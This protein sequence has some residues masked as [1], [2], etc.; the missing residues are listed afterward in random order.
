[1][2]PVGQRDFGFVRGIFNRD[3]L[4]RLS[5]A[6]RFSGLGFA[7]KLLP[8]PACRLRSAAAAPGSARG[9][10]VR[11]AGPGTASCPHLFPPAIVFV[12]VSMSTSAHTHTHRRLYTRIHIHT[13]AYTYTHTYPYRYGDTNMYPYPYPHIRTRRHTHISMYIYIHLQTPPH[14]LYIHIHRNTHKPFHIQT[15]I[16]IEIRTHI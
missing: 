4:L 6:F 8:A 15:P 16:P 7:A 13:H 1:M 10:S 11:P 14:T 5:P 12:C 3:A 2:E 9:A